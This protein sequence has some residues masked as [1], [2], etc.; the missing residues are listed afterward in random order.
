M[1]MARGHRK[2]AEPELGHSLQIARGDDERLRGLGRPNHGE[3]QLN[4]FAAAELT[5]QLP[6]AC[7]GLERPHDDWAAKP[8]ALDALT[9]EPRLMR[10]E[11]FPEPRPVRRSMP[12]AFLRL[13]FGGELR[14]E[15]TLR[16]FP[17]TVH[18]TNASRFDM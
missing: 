3:A 17:D 15:R 7:H 1:R 10:A 18:C 5:L 16:C 11:N 12:P 9:S 2:R 14:G 8:Q 13:E 6:E 4:V